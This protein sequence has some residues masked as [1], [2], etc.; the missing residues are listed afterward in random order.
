MTASLSVRSLVA[1]TCA[2]QVANAFRTISCICCGYD[3]PAVSCRCSLFSYLDFLNKNSRSRDDERSEKTVEPCGEVTE[4][5]SKGRFATWEGTSNVGELYQDHFGRTMTS[6]RP[7]DSTNQR[8]SIEPSASPWTQN[9]SYSAQPS[10][11][12]HQHGFSLQ[13]DPMAAVS[14]YFAARTASQQPPFFDPCDNNQQAEIRPS[15]PSRQK[16]AIQSLQD[17]EIRGNP[18]YAVGK[19]KLQERGLPQVSSKDKF[20]TLDRRSTQFDFARESDKYLNFSS[21]R[22]GHD[23]LEPVIRPIPQSSP[24]LTLSSREGGSPT[25]GGSIMEEHKSNAMFQSHNQANVLSSRSKKQNPRTD[26]DRFNDVIS[27]PSPFRFLGQTNPNFSLKD[28][29]DVRPKRA[30]KSADVE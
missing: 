28:I 26:M 15:V 30:D 7:N 10:E 23:R 25:A 12:G 20:P 22:I 8:R 18:F 11:T 17:V 29:S 13:Y 6:Q 21:Q 5:Y 19:D 9:D 16:L 27:S 14:G 2:V 24:L 4:D 1:F 3:K